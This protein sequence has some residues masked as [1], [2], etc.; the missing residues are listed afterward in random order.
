MAQ[1]PLP[2]NTVTPLQTYASIFYT[3]NSQANIDLVMLAPATNAFGYTPGCILAQYTSGSLKGQFVNYVPSG[4]NGQGTPKAIL[5]DN[6]LTPLQS[7]GTGGTPV[8]IGGA[9]TE[10]CWGSA[11]LFASP[12]YWT[13]PGGSDDL[14]TVLGIGAGLIPAVFWGGVITGTAPLVRLL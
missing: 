7:N 2:Q 5:T 4:A 14:T 1:T 10:V 13:T 8:G 12:I 3:D 11:T 6:Y 9:M